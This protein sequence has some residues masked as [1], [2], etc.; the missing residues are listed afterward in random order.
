MTCLWQSHKECCCT[1]TTDESQWKEQP[2]GTYSM[3]YIVTHMKA[4][5]TLHIATVGKVCPCMHAIHHHPP[6]QLNDSIHFHVV[7]MTATLPVSLTICWGFHPRTPESSQGSLWTHHRSHWR[8]R[9]HYL[10]KTQGLEFNIRGQFV[11]SGSSGTTSL[12]LWEVCDL[13]TILNAYAINQGLNYSRDR[14][15]WGHCITTWNIKM[16]PNHNRQ[17]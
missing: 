12:V 3:T 2:H 8:S 17:R 10:P 1:S 16:S 15:F 11:I 5:W 9:C 7:I 13:W 14:G 6:P 4:L